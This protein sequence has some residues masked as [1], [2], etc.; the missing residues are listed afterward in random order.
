MKIKFLPFLL[1]PF[2]LGCQ[3]QKEPE[4]ELPEVTYETITYNVENSKEAV[5]ILDSQANQDYF[6]S[7]FDVENSILT[8][9]TPTNLF[10]D[11]GGL[12]FGTSKA[13]SS[14]S[15]DT[16]KQ[17][18]KINLEVAPYG[19]FTQYYSSYDANSKVKVNDQTSEIL[20]GND[21]EI[22]KQNVEFT[23]DAT[24][25]VVIENIFDDTPREDGNKQY[26]RF[27]IFNFTLTFIA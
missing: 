6:Y 8:N 5:G 19:K 14:L 26:A 24:N 16:T 25:R 20:N 2:L 1:I 13:N 11:I 4:E 17:V 21:S 10:M 22:V 18:T 7:L 12:R 27:I 9:I 23:F 15:F 3:N